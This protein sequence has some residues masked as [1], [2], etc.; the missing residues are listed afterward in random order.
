MVF[1]SLRIEKKLIYI[2]MYYNIMSGKNLDGVP[3]Y[4]KC[5]KDTVFDTP[6]RGK[7]KTY[8]WDQNEQD[9][10]QSMFA[11]RRHQ[12][13]WEDFWKHASLIAHIITSVMVGCC[14]HDTWRWVCG[15]CCGCR[16]SDSCVDRWVVRRKNSK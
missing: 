11:W 9:R 12:R 16:I 5:T 3:H 13:D 14:V 2:Y 1:L 10:S 4:Y 15:V 6:T 7:K 8:A